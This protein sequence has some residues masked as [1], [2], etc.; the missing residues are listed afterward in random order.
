[1]SL[2]VLFCDN[3]A[4]HF[5]RQARKITQLLYEKF[6]WEVFLHFRRCVDHQLSDLAHDFALLGAELVNASVTEL[7]NIQKSRILPKVGI[8][9]RDSAWIDHVDKMLLDFS[10]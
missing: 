4:H 6:R 8:A 1:M 7:E 10:D 9:G 2:G 5:I 3:T